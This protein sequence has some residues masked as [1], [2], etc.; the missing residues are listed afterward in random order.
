M[1]PLVALYL[2][3]GAQI[4]L[5]IQRRRKSLVTANHALLTAMNVEE[6]C[7]L[8]TMKGRC[9]WNSEV[10]A[11]TSARWG[12]MKTG[13]C[14]QESSLLAMHQDDPLFLGCY[15]DV[16]PVLDRECSGRSHCEV[17]VPNADLD[18]IESCY[19]EL[20]R[21]LEVSYACVKGRTNTIK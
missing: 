4:G 14:L 6:V 5:H 21:Y 7:N 16:L 13:R 2:N 1:G 11:M 19:P 9:R 3:P 15:K 17:R 8:E 20:E 18:Q 12:R 10:I